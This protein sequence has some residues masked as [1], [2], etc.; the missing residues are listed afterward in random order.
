MAD[1]SP[2]RLDTGDARPFAAPISPSAPSSG[3]AACLQV[4]LMLMRDRKSFVA[5]IGHAK[6][7]PHKIVGLLVC[8]AILLA[9]YGLVLGAVHSPVQSIVSAIKL[10]IL[11]FLTSI[12][13]F[14]TLYIFNSFIGSRQSFLQYC[15]LVLA[16][17][18][19]ISLLMLGFFPVSLF[20]LL[21]LD[22]AAF[23]TLLNIAIVGLT[24]T[25]GTLFLC[26]SIMDLETR[27]RARFRRPLF[28]ASWFALYSAIGCQL[29]WHLS[30][31]FGTPGEPFVLL[32]DGSGN[33]FLA[34][35]ELLAGGP[36]Q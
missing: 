20:F 7:L 18:D 27:A 16:S 29:A 25:I 9:V 21:T 30:P 35:L 15:T 19:I 6:Q 34:I 10:P 2:Q 28:L 8:G 32:G 5:E 14:P 22:D 12:V 24:G 17:I 3:L 4:T 1:R 26:G 23:F 36:T 11:F 31:F 13:C 33:F